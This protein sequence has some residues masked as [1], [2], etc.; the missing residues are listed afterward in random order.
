MW[1]HDFISGKGMD[2]FPLVSMKPA[3]P[4][5]IHPFTSFSGCTWQKDNVNQKR[6]DIV[7]GWKHQSRRTKS[8][9]ERQ[10]L[11][12]RKGQHY[13]ATVTLTEGP[14]LSVNLRR[15]RVQSEKKIIN[16]RTMSIKE[17]HHQSKKDA[18][19]QRR[20]PSIKE[21]R[22]QSKKDAINQRRTTSIMVEQHFSQDI[23]C[24]R[25]HVH[26]QSIRKD[27]A[28]QKRIISSIEEKNQLK[29][30]KQRRTTINRRRRKSTTVRI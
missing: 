15:T 21:G 1:D 30:I 22:H 27:N 26:T 7:W 24:I 28:I 13:P 29:N 2:N 11:H 23:F 20:T 19:N 6:K 9:T 3:S 18:I 17:G 4:V 16:Q 25:Q 14:H 5:W 8:R 12:I 10:N